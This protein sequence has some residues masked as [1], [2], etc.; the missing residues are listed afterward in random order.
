MALIICPECGG[1]ISDKA[2]CCIHCGFP[3]EKGFNKSICPVFICPECKKAIREQCDICPNCGSE[4]DLSNPM[5]CKI[6]G[7]DYDLSY[8][9]QEL[10]EKEHSLSLM[11]RLGA[12]LR[13]FADLSNALFLCDI[14]MKTGEVPKEYNYE[15]V[16]E[17]R[18]KRSSEVHCKYCGSTNVKKLKDNFFNLGNQW[19]CNNCGSDF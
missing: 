18:K 12:E 8:F 9:Y 10:T 19:H 5:V 1:E 7:V 16:T 3:I 2:K 13:D 15:S 6:N 17:W 11:G 14:I 4:V